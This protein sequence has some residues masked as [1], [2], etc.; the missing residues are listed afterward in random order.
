VL[1][2]PIRASLLRAIS[3]SLAREPCLETALED[4]LERCLDATSSRFAAVYLA[5]SG[6]D[7]PVRVMVDRTGRSGGFWEQQGALDPKALARSIPPSEVPPPPEGHLHGGPGAS[8][9]VVAAIGDVHRR[10]GVLWL[11]CAHAELDFDEWQALANTVATQIAQALAR[12]RTESELSERARLATLFADV[13]IALASGDPLTTCLDR[14]AAA[15]HHQL[16][17][18]VARIWMH[19]ESTGTL[20][21]A[22][23]AGNP[24]RSAA[25]FAEP[26]VQSVLKERRPFLRVSAEVVFVAHPLLVEDRLLGVLTLLTRAPLTSAATAALAPVAD[27]IAVGIERKIVQ[28]EQ[29]E[30][31]AQFLQAQKMEAIGQLSGSIAH[32]FNNLLAVILSCSALLLD[33]L[34]EGDRRRQDVLD[35]QHSGERAASL[36]RQ[37][38]AFSRKLVVEPRVIEIN[39]VVMNVQKI[40]GR[41]IGEDVELRIRLNAHDSRV[42]ADPGQLE[43]L[44][45]NLAVN[46]RDAMP[47]GGR[48]LI[49]TERVTLDDKFLEKQG[50]FAAGPYVRTSV[51]DSGCGMDA[52]TRSHIFEPFFSTK[53]VGKGTGLGLST[54]YGIVQQSGGFIHVES[55]PGMGSSFHVYLPSSVE[56]ISRAPRASSQRTSPQGCGE[57]ILLVEDEARVRSLAARILRDRGYQVVEASGADAAIESLK[58]SSRAPELLITD[59]VMPGPSGPDLADLLRKRFPTLKVLFMSGHTDHPIVLGGALGR[60]MGFLHKPFTPDTLA[61]KVQSLLAR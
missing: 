40:L 23:S 54:V 22:A 60:A 37:L 1:R 24:G 44:I 28:K 36:T 49:S 30:L 59:M 18:S 4:V 35:I 39:E 38:L 57:L 29:S 56:S 10:S 25:P 58:E 27:A 61:G 16:G 51:V 3:E 5:D 7:A 19:H 42:K 31:Q 26:E 55:T 11:E 14:C 21:I 13:S 50:A 6:G 43:Q 41:L 2:S 12:R 47:A 20:S 46:A 17:A 32:D 53:A 52:E 9:A 48:L 34:P 45:M 15:L 33:E 8:R